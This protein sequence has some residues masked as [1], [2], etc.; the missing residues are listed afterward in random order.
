[1]SSPELH[2]AGATVRPRTPFNDI[3]VPARLHA[4]TDKA[5]IETWVTPLYLRGLQDEEK[6]IEVLRPQR[7]EITAPLIGELLSIYNWRPRIV[8]AYLAA[9]VCESSLLD[10]VGRLLL[11]SDVCYAG[12][13]YC[14]A[15]ARFGGDDARDYLT[16]YLDY[17]LT[18]G[19]L[20]FEQCEALA[21]LVYLDELEG[22]SVATRYADFWQEFVKDKPNWDLETSCLSHRSRIT[23]L[24]R[25][26]DAIDRGLPEQQ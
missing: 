13:G 21:A 17:Y 26:A 15:L 16:R 19:D 1:M 14:L 7:D 4:D 10:Q 22:T 9:I 6:L 8:G 11:R 2:A 5:L 12:G 18:R 23:M 3:E 24:E 20:W 25:V